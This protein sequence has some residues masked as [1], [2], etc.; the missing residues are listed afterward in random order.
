MQRYGSKNEDS[1]KLLDMAKKVWIKFIKVTSKYFEHAILNAR[2][3]HK[4]KIISND[5]FLYI[6]TL[7]YTNDFMYVFFTKFSI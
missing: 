1:E 5:F 6:L 4:L 2:T 7:I 3:V